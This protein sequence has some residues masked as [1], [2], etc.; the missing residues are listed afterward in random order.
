MGGMNPEIYVILE[1]MKQ[2]QNQGPVG[3]SEHQI[4]KSLSIGM[5]RLLVLLAEEAEARG[6]EAETQGVRFAEQTE[7]LITFTKAL[8]W[9]TVGLVLITAFQ[10]F[11]ML[12]SLSH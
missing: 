5:A 12:K 4:Q 10:I 9:L 8:T 11:L 6:K 3:S 2:K 1:E 7:K